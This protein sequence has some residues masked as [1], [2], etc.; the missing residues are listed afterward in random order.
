MKA[1][2]QAKIQELKQMVAELE[3]SLQFEEP[4]LQPEESRR[5]AQYWS[6]YFNWGDFE[7]PDQDT[8][9]PTI[10]DK[11]ELDALLSAFSG[12]GNPEV[13]RRMETAICHALVNFTLLENDNDPPDGD[14]YDEHFFFDITDA[15]W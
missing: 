5:T 12:E 6:R 9:I 8:R 11:P 13:E 4:D 3:D 15:P 14:E 7:Y 2:Q 1:E 10:T